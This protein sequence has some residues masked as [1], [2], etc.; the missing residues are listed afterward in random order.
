MLR[1][2][3]CFLCVSLVNKSMVFKRAYC[4]Y[5]SQKNYLFKIF[6]ALLHLPIFY[7]ASCC[8]FFSSVNIVSDF[9][10][11]LIITEH[12]N[13]QVAVFIFFIF[14]LTKQQNMYYIVKQK[15]LHPSTN[16]ALTTKSNAPYWHSW[17]LVMGAWLKELH[18]QT[19]VHTLCVRTFIQASVSIKWSWLGGRGRS[20]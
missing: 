10:S 16:L 19:S 3:I 20:L 4:P 12:T 9:A 5:F 7:L 17:D 18:I 6:A 2:N 15:K 13:I 8:F 11:I 1:S 14:F